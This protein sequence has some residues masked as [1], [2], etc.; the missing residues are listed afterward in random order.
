MYNVIENFLL[1]ENI[2]CKE[3]LLEVEFQYIAIVVLD[4]VLVI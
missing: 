1:I 4:F 2:S 3:I